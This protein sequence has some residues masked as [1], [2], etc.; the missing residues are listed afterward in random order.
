MLIGL[1]LT[2][3]VQAKPTFLARVKARYPHLA[4]SRLDGCGLCH[5]GGLGGAEL[6]PFAEAFSQ[7]GF[8]LAAIEGFDS[9]GDGHTN[10][11][12][13]N[14]LTFPGNP[15]NFPKSAVK[16]TPTPV[17]PLAPCNLAQNPTENSYSGQLKVLPGGYSG[18]V[19]SSG[20]IDIFELLGI[21]TAGETA[22][23]ML[24]GNAGRGQRLFQAATI[25]PQNTSGCSVC[26]VARTDGPALGP[27]QFD[28][29][30][31]AAEVI[32]RSD[33]TGRAKT[34]AEYLR[35][36]MLEPHIYV[37]PGFTAG[38]MP[39]SYATDLTEQEI[40]DL[41]AYMLTLK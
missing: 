29:A 5:R 18:V 2:P 6:N 17:A 41:V 31:R 10:L 12:E 15:K 16:A 14:A 33:Y 24:I 9:D 36:S 1:W 23:P 8:D 11:A 4:G 25:G 22:P 19:S 39:K 32:L 20:L 13:I 3:V 27:P 35:E 38:L 21:S 28:L 7:N 37:T 40:A 34:V 30:S 26:H